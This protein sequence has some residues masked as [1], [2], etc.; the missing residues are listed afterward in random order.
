[1]RESL[2]C[3]RGG[4]SRDL[5]ELVVLEGGLVLLSSNT[6]AN[7]EE[8]KQRIASVLDSGAAM[9]KFEQMMMKQVNVVLTHYKVSKHVIMRIAAS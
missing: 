5:R 9:K 2:D 6:V 3:L 7:L 1:M 8:G 4:G